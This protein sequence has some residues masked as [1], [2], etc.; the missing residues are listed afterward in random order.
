MRVC[1]LLPSRLLLASACVSLAAIASAQPAPTARS[2]DPWVA[3]PTPNGAQLLP[4][5]LLERATI[6]AEIARGVRATLRAPRR[7][8]GAGRDGLQGVG[9]LAWAGMAGAPPPP[10]NDRSGTHRK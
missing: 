2:L 7:V 8:L 5:A 10:V 1:A 3:R 4:K 6:P 9:A